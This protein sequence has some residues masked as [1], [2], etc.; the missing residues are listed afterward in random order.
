MF[1]ATMV[2]GEPIRFAIRNSYYEFYMRWTDEVLLYWIFISMI[3]LTILWT[4]LLIS[5]V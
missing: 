1:P 5:I 3:N 2:I 4:S